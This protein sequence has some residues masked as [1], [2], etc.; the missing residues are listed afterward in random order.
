LEKGLDPIIQFLL[1]SF[2]CLL[3]WP[4]GWGIDREQ[5]VDEIAGL[6]LI[7]I[8]ENAEHLIDDLA[9]QAP[10][11]PQFGFALL[12]FFRVILLAALVS[13]DRNL[14]EGDCVQGA[15]KETVA[16]WVSVKAIM[17]AA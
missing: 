2:Q 10:E 15:V 13:L 16:E 14:G 6:G 12:E 1:A 17:P 5:S 8:A 9:F 4:E 3:Q 11:R 7:V